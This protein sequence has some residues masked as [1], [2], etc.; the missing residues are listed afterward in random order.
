MQ[1]NHLLWKAA[2]DLPTITLLGKSFIIKMRDNGAS[3]SCSA[4]Y[5]HVVYVSDSV[6]EFRANS[7]AAIGG[8]VP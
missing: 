6:P 1:S 3:P 2:T 4:R 8:M 5:Q 7:S